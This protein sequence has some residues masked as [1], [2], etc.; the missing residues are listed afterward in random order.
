ML[1]IASL[2]AEIERQEGEAVALQQL[3][4]KRQ[5][6]ARDLQVQYEAMEKRVFDQKTQLDALYEQQLQFAT[7]R[8]DLANRIDQKRTELNLSFGVNG[9]KLGLGYQDVSHRV[10][11][12]HK[13]FFF[14]QFS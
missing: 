5:Q 4:A 7:Q 10:D 1:I 3:V 12:W 11:I 8:E 13:P 2:N 14:S 6:E 9:V